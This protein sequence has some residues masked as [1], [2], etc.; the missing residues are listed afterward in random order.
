MFSIGAEVDILPAVPVHA[1]KS[2]HSNIPPPPDSSRSQ[3]ELNGLPRSASYTHLPGVQQLRP[4]EGIKRTFSDNVLAVLPDGSAKN[5]QSPYAP[6]KE[7]LQSASKSA[8]AKIAFTKFTLS[9]EDLESA[10][11]NGIQ[12]PAA[13]GVSVKPR[14]SAGHSVSSTFRSLARRSWRTSLSRSPSPSPKEARRR[15]KSVHPSP[16]K[17]HSA[18]TFSRPVASPSP[19]PVASRP[20][21]RSSKLDD[22]E[23]RTSQETGPVLREQTPQ[24]KPSRRP[25]SAIMQRNRSETELMPSRK[26]SLRSLRSRGSSDKLSSLPPVKVPPLPSSLSSDKLSSLNF[27]IKKKGDPLWSVFRTLDGD[28]QK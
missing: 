18:S 16:D 3:E 20:S 5:A 22:Y 8:K 13:V 24:H 7:L 12:K 28:F 2:L 27:D 19:S 9:P 17:K 14:S 1:L 21:S 23:L 11:G 4:T 15:A 26:P 25:L 6:S 10:T